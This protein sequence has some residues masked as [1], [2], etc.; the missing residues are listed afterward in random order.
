MEIGVIGLGNIGLPIS[1]NLMR[2]G[3]RVI[4]FDVRKNTD[5]EAAGGVQVAQCHEIAAAPVV[6]QSLPSVA[7]LTTSIDALLERPHKGQAVIELSS[8]SLADKAAQAKRLAAYGVEMLD[9]E[10]SGLAHQVVQ[11]EG[12]IF[13][14]GS[15][16]ISERLDPVFDAM[17]SRH[18]YLGAFGAATKMKLVA[19]ALVCVHNSMAAEALVLGKKLGLD[20]V[21]MIQVLVP[22]AAGSR[23]FENKAPLMVSRKFENGSGPFRHMFGYLDR[24][25]QLAS[26]AGVVTP[27]IDSTAALFETAKQ[28][29]RHDQDIAAMIE[30]LENM[31]GETA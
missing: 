21:Q 15:A 7:A 18:F 6:I 22:S 9:C 26:Q 5:F 25:R 30:I 11:R 14:S 23:T 16:E 3:F 1:L 20:P 19:N 28:Q 27:L 12:V 4:G 17:A 31:S 10:I 8:Y 2:A 13:K 24:I 29:G